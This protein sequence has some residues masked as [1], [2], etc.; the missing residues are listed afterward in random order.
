MS[1]VSTSLLILD[2]QLF[3]VPNS[4]IWGDVIKNVTWQ[5]IRCVDMRFSGPAFVWTF[6]F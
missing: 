3:V 1:L 5:D 6:R 2:N 4:K